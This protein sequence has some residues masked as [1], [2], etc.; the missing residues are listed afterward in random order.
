MSK[1]HTKGRAC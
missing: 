1:I